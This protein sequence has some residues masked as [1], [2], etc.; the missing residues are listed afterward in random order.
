MCAAGRRIVSPDV[1]FRTSWHS[2]CTTIGEVPWEVT[3]GGEQV[4]L[5]AL[6]LVGQPFERR[7]L[8]DQ[9]VDQAHVVFGRFPD[10]H[11][12]LGVTSRFAALTTAFSEA[13]RMEESMPTPH[14]VSPSGPA[15]S[16]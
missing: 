12:V 5:T 9:T 6:D 2:P 8:D 3:I 4:C 14:Q 13:S 1:M 7:Q 16:T 11:G 10:D 15:A